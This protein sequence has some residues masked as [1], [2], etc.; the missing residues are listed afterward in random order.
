MLTKTIYD[1]C[2]TVRKGAKPEGDIGVKTI[3]GGKYAIFRHKGNYEKFN[4]S[5]NYIFGSLMTENNAE[6]DDKPC[7]ELSLN[8]PDKT[9]PEKLLTGIYIP[10]K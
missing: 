7:F 6:R 1:A 5:Y 10:L 9:K 3:E 8:S 4:D 2:I